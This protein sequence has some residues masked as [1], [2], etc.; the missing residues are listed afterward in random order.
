MRV[1]DFIDLCHEQSTP[2]HV[3]Q[4]FRKVAEGVGFRTLA[5]LPVTPAARNAFGLSELDL[6]L[7]AEVPEAWKQHYVAENYVECD[8]VL[9]RTPLNDGP[10]VWKS[11]VGDP[12]LT[13]KQRRVLREGEEAGLTHGVSVPVHGARGETYMVTLAGRDQ[14][15]DNARDLRR[16][17]MLTMHFVLAYREGVHK[18]TDEY[19]ATG[20]SDRERDCL[21]WTAR[22][23]SAWA[24][25]KILNVS[26]HT[27]NFHLK[28]SMRKLGAANRMQAV[29]TALR[30]G[31]IL[32]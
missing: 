2:E 28:S 12:K 31:L 10:L 8:P 3:F 29:V 16:L 4:T 15:I 26:E 19:L 5:L 20:I 25:S 6:V 7:S 13:A 21:T 30:L 11:L 9:L 17:H 1:S 14:E 24:I 18:R 23:K 27:V 32:P 22:G